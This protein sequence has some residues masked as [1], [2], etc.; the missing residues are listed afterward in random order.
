MTIATRREPKSAQIFQSR[1][2]LINPETLFSYGTWLD[3]FQ[4]IFGYCKT[5]RHIDQSMLDKNHQLSVIFTDLYFSK[6]YRKEPNY[7][8]ARKT[9]SKLGEINSW[10]SEPNDRDSEPHLKVEEL[11]LGMYQFH[12]ATC[13]SVGSSV[14]SNSHR[15]RLNRF[16][17]EDI[18]RWDLSTEKFLEIVNAIESILAGQGSPFLCRGY[19]ELRLKFAKIKVKAFYGDHTLW[20]SSEG[21][22]DEDEDGKFSWNLANDFFAPEYNIQFI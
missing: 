10:V 22:D 7:E 18:V 5:V 15:W 4:F 2:P 13:L 6:V 1:L 9:L 14:G 17:K 21:E 12:N 3:I 16:R 8:S 20:P 19:F 11:N